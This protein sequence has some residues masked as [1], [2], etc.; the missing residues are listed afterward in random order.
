VVIGRGMDIE[1]GISNRAERCRGA[2]RARL[3]LKPSVHGCKFADRL[4]K[5]E[6]WSFGSVSSAILWLE[7][8]L[9]I[10]RKA[11]SRNRSNLKPE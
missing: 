1:K 9:R 3:L 7:M 11:N 6:K 4:E 5:T 2:H 10:G 8:S